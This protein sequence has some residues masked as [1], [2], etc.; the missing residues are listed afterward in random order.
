MRIVVVAYYATQPSSVGSRRIGSLIEG[1]VSGEHHVT[2]VAAGD[3][4]APVPTALT[5]AQVLTVDPRDRV[6]RL[7][8]AVARFRV[9]RPGAATSPDAAPPQ[10]RPQRTARV[11]AALRPWIAFPDTVWEWTRVAQRATRELDGDERPDLVFA[12][13]PPMACLHAAAHLANHWGCPWIADMRDLWSDDPYRVVPTILRPIDRRLERR[14]LRDAA[15]LVTVAEPL[16]DLLR[17]RHP[18]RPVHVIRNGFDPAWLRTGDL[19]PATPPRIVFTGTARAGSGRDF[20]PVLDSLAR[21]AGPATRVRLHVYGAMSSDVRERIASH[22]MNGAVHL[23]GM[24]LPE[25]ARQAQHSAALL[26]SLGWDDPRDL[27]SCPA[28]LFEYAAARRP[29]LHIGATGTVGAQM[30]RDFGL[31]YVVDAKDTAQIESLVERAVND[32]LD[33]RP[34]APAALEPLSSAT[35]VRRYLEVIDDIG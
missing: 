28:K 27:G 24:V 18:G 34:P 14:V 10:R 2:V 23:H 3:A 12:T 31:G 6:E 7:R 11:A 19:P 4:A 35:M 5:G 1:L 21:G 13:A 20:V 8:N 16:A 25:V 29:I 30:I 33:W 22:P 15:A 26:L 17:S 32:D 9:R